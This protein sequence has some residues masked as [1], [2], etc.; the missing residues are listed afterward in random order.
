MYNFW[1]VISQKL[2]KIVPNKVYIIVPWS[3]FYKAT[4]STAGDMISGEQDAGFC[5]FIFND[6]G[7]NGLQMATTCSPGHGTNLQPLL[8]P[9]LGGFKVARVYH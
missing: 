6:I 5:I 7:V 1:P 3:L 2:H 8:T 4:Y 9:M